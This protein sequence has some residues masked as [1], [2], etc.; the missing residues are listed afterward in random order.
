MIERELLS[1][2]SDCGMAPHLTPN[3]KLAVRF[4]HLPVTMGRCSTHDLHPARSTPSDSYAGDEGSLT[5]TCPLPIELGFPRFRCTRYVRSVERFL[6]SGIHNDTNPCHKIRVMP[7]AKVA[8]VAKY[9]CKEPPAGTKRN[10]T[11]EQKLKQITVP[12]S[13]TQPPE[14]KS[15]HLYPPPREN[16]N[17]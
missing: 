4:R 3:Q 8:K 13:D 10:W 11:S 1:H 17:K 6:A 14:N 9:N 15:D 12:F 7:Q 2:Y 16:K 5:G